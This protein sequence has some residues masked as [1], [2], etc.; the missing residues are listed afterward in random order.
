MVNKWL[1]T[2]LD[3]RDKM[4]GQNFNTWIKPI[5]FGSADE[6][7]LTLIVPSKFFKDWISD[8]F[9]FIIEDSVHSIFGDDHAIV[10]KIDGQNFY[11]EE[12][13]EKLKRRRNKGKNRRKQP[14]I[15]RINPPKRVI[16][17]LKTTWC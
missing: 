1:S 4:T 10:F 2:L 8:N 3:I 9:L 6:S 5:K 17:S 13:S 12:K 14:K 7:S 16:A 15:V 11:K